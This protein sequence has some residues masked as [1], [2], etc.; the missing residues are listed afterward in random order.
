MTDF[1]HTFSF[2]ADSGTFT[3]AAGDSLAIAGASLQVILSDRTLDSVLLEIAGTDRRGEERPGLGHGVAE[4]IRFAAGDGVAVALE[5]FVPDAGECVVLRTELVNEGDA[6]IAVE[7]LQPLVLE[8]EEGLVSL[9]MPSSQWAVLRE[10]WHS[11]SPTGVL[12]IADGDGDT[13]GARDDG[14]TSE[15][16]TVLVAGEVDRALLLGWLEAKRLTNRFLVARQGD[17]AT[18]RAVA[19]ADGVPLGP[20]ATL[21]SEPLVIRF[22]ADPLAMLERYGDLLGERMASRVLRPTTATAD[23]GSNGGTAA[24]VQPSA[25]GWLSRQTG[26][27]VTDAMIRENL[28]PYAPEAERWQLDYWIIDDGWQSVAGDWLVINEKRFPLGMK[29]V[30]DGIRMAGPKPGLSLAPLL[31]SEA[32]VL[33]RE[34]VDWLLRD[35]R[36]E[37]VI[38]IEFPEESYWRG[39]QFVLDV[40]HPEAADHLRTVIRTLVRDWG[41]ACVKADFLFAGALPGKRHDPTV[42]ATQAMRR[43]LEIIRDEVGQR[44]LLVCR[45]PIGPAI[46]LADACRTG[47]DV[48]GHWHRADQSPGDPSTKSAVGNV[49]ARYWQHGRLFVADPDVLMARQEA[50]GLTTSEVQTLATVVAM[51]GGLAMWSDMLDAVAPERRTLIDMILPAWPRAARPVD[52]FRHQGSQTLVWDIERGEQSWKVVALLN[53][54]DLPADLSL[55]LGDIDCDDGRRRHVFELWQ[56]KY[57]GAVIGSLIVPAVPPHGVRL[58]VVRAESGGLDFLGSTLH[59]TGGA[60]FCDVEAKGLACDVRLSPEWS[61]RGRLLFCPPAGYVVRTSDGLLTPRDD[62]VWSIEVDTSMTTEYHFEAVHQKA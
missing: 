62:G 22:A 39:R 44:F 7:E 61:R 15:L 6:A 57:Y 54:S 52:L 37:V 5:A 31:V 28:A 23:N 58:L 1:V 19:S 26:V 25:G 40:T 27:T 60:A 51:S 41:F 21:A 43:A 56:Q 16:V 12:S 20:G 14:I 55:E 49:I 45:C 33:A 10:G 59:A 36:D 32:S 17:G 2:D 50:D 46:G 47:P 48:A 34:H 18:I 3:I 42:T 29:L 35:E 4:T 30:A 24:V 8:G 9:G 53:L 11:G 38:A 13:R